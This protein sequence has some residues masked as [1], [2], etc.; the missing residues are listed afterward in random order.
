M[1]KKS[2]KPLSER[3]RKGA[4]GLL[5]IFLLIFTG[6]G[7]LRLYGSL[8]LW[9]Y[10]QEIGL[11]SSPLYLAITGGLWVITGVIGIFFHLSKRKWS[12][13]YMRILSLVFSIWFWLDLW[14]FQPQDRRVHNWEFQL[15]FN[16]LVLVLVF[17]L[18]ALQL[19]KSYSTKS[20]EPIA[21]TG[22]EH[23]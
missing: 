2:Q 9:E 19:Y 21:S 14:I 1:E 7:L 13:A 11:R 23:A 17:G 8:T 22:G 20:A 6:F 4:H 3:I 18:S 12:I 5:S 15:I 16:I 10:L